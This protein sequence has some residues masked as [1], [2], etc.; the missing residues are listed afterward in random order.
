MNQVKSQEFANVASD[1]NA[2]SLILCSAL[3]LIALQLIGC[4]PSPASQTMR[5]RDKTSA[6]S[7]ASPQDTRVLMAAP[8]GPSMTG[9]A[10]AVSGTTKK[11]LETLSSNLVNDT[12]EAS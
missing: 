1:R 10:P 8:P 11:E 5:S 6:D 12:E 3:G 9:T 2:G 7:P 4:D